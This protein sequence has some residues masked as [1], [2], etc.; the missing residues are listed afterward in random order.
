[1]DGIPIEWSQLTECVKIEP[2]DVR[3]STVPSP[4][5]SASQSSYH[6]N[7]LKTPPYNATGVQ[8][9]KTMDGIP[10]IWSQPTEC[11]KIEPSDERFSAVPLPPISTSQSSYHATLPYNVTGVQLGET[12]VCIGLCA[13]FVDVF[14]KI[15]VVLVTSVSCKKESLNVE[16]LELHGTEVPMIM[17]ISNSL[18]VVSILHVGRSYQLVPTWMEKSRTFWPDFVLF[19][20]ASEDCHAPS[21]FFLKVFDLKP[22][23]LLMCADSYI[24]NIFAFNLI[25]S[26]N[27]L[28]SSRTQGDKTLFVWQPS[29]TFAAVRNFFQVNEKKKIVESGYFSLLSPLLG[30]GY[31]FHG[32]KEGEYCHYGWGYKEEKV[33]NHFISQLTLVFSAT[34]LKCRGLQ[35]LQNPR[36][37]IFQCK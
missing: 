31:F 22:S 1:M 32:E 3:F 11:V 16:G 30:S 7:D 6:T 20:T 5:I 37:K 15:R 26:I 4:P 18:A 10:I 17:T 8:L 25:K 19:V 14:Q 36:S 24:L 23:P 13:Q 34:D 27:S 12:M 35:L 29:H 9:G 33:C 2:S 28:L 21:E